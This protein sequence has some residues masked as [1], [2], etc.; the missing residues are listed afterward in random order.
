MTSVRNTC[1][2]SFYWLYSLSV[3][4]AADQVAWVGMGQLR[5]IVEVEAAD[6]NGRIEDEWPAALQIDFEREL[7]RLGIK[8]R[9]DLTSIQVMRI[10]PQTGD[11]QS[12]RKYRYARS[13]ADR[14]FR[15]YDATIPTD[16]PEF[17]GNVSSTQGKIVRKPR[18][19]AG[20]FLPT[21]GEWKRGR[22][23]WSH[24][25]SGQY[26]SRYAIYFDLLSTGQ[27]PTETPPRGWLGDG[28][29]RC[30]VA[31]HTSVGADHCRLDLDDWNDDGLL[32]LIVGETY[33]HL[34]WFPNCGQPGS[35]RFP[36][37]K[38]VFEA[39]GTPLDAGMLLAPKVVDWDNDGLKDLLAG[40]ERNRI[41][42]YRNIGTNQ[43]RRLKYQG[44]LQLDGQPLQ[45]PV[46]P[47]GWGSTD[48]FKTD[49]YPVLETVDWDQDGDVDLLAGG[50][51]TGRIFRYENQGKDA[52]GRPKLA[53]RGPLTT[54]G[55]ALNVGDWCAA[56]C[57]ADLD[58]DG[59]LDLLSGCMPMG[60]RTD[61]DRKAF[62]RFFK[63]VGTR[64]QV[65]FQQMPFPCE[66]DFPTS[67]L[68]TPRAWDWDADGDL[69]LV[70]SSRR[71][72]YMFKNVGS[73]QKPRF[74]AHR[75]PLPSR[76]G[77]AP[78]SAK[79]FVDWDQ[80]GHL[81]LVSN[82]TVR[83]NS[84]SGNPGS[85]D[86][87]LSILPEGQSIAH[88]SGFG[89]D[90]FW[91]YVDDFDGDGLRDVLFGDWF[92]HVWFHRNLSEGPQ[93]RFDLKGYRLQ[94]DGGQP[95]KVGPL[96]KDP[97][98]SFVAL[99]G[100]RTVLTV[101]DF[102]RDGHRD[103]VIGDT[104]GKVRYFRQ[105][106]S[107]KPLTFETPQLV[108]DLGIRLLVDAVD[109]NQ[110]GWPDVIA[111]AANGRVR[112]FLNRR[113]QGDSRFLRGTD[114]GLPPRTEDARQLA[115]SL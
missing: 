8:E 113:G 87:S 97:A 108:G 54:K 80:D 73:P 55:A 17:H 47:L 105:R 15:W 52:D 11:S 93:R 106:P 29:P 81:D 46:T 44:V 107:E 9:P 79:R 53:F 94:V 21:L 31:G 95:I 2:W 30:D 10:D 59:D 20:F 82:Y 38:L 37:A 43:N 88:P 77:S 110:D 40:T 28:L 99:Q 102:D 83:L 78:I 51:I 5:I 27:E 98:K 115:G 91:P 111:G 22:L 7:Q 35:P 50:Y 89:D 92:G 48:V 49:Y 32:D 42:Y 90:W 60:K 70:V 57:L 23:A 41:L 74:A 104:Y 45:V 12:Y 3:L 6:L 39:D 68:A 101:A 112:V 72:I 62:L 1:L 13:E 66:G 85:W 86:R 114:P 64:G 26:P 14:P 71:N 4:E 24:T 56:P 65:E 84:G 69:D 16:F 96:N 100:A 76:W 25:Q 36:Y 34:L 103:L 18:R 109:W 63:N 61:A 19:N 75:N 33:G 58:A 67:K